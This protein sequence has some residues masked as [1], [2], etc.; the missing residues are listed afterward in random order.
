ML[1]LN[2]IVRA[3][4]SETSLELS[5]NSDYYCSLT[6]NY[7]NNKQLVLLVLETT[8]VGSCVRECMYSC[9]HSS[10]CM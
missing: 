6:C 10:F 8:S 4:L 2:N 1:L 7:K 9:V 5:K 3:S